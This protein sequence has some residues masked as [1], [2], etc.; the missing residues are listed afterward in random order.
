MPAK[1]PR[2][3]EEKAMALNYPLRPNQGMARVSWKGRACDLGPFGSLESLV[4]LLALRT[5]LAEGNAPPQMKPFR[6]DAM[7]EAGFESTGRLE[8]VERESL[9]IQSENASLEEKLSECESSLA[10]V[11]EGRD[12][13]I[14]KL[15]DADQTRERLEAGLAAREAKL[16]E[17]IGSRNELL[18]RRP[19]GLWVGLSIAIGIAVISTSLWATVKPRVGNEPLTEVETQLIGQ[20]RSG[21]KIARS[22]KEPPAIDGRLLSEDEIAAIRGVR[23]GGLQIRDVGLPPEFEGSV[24]SELEMN[25]LRQL[26]ANTELRRS[27]LLEISTEKK[28]YRNRIGVT[29]WLETRK[30]ESLAKGDSPLP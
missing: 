12:Q 15:A 24:L 6:I 2:T 14:S 26:R 3:D 23:G 5:Y 13:L 21:E 18:K 1:L 22:P 16:A 29:E 10:K 11:V 4:T 20:L 25:S 17:T 27:R 9:R 30:A 19:T 7:R 8:E 28:D